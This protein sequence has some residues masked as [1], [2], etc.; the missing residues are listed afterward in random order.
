MNKIIYAGLAIVFA[1]VTISCDDDNDKV[2]EQAE[3][4]ETAMNFL[5]LHFPQQAIKYTSRDEDDYQVT[6][7]N[8]IALEFNLDGSWDE[9]KGNGVEIP[10]SDR[11]STRLNSSHS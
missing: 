8:G 3:L 11:K 4:P 10:A 1:M 6:L 9:I 2:I 5:E 7:D